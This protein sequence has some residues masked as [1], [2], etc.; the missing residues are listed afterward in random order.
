MLSVLIGTNEEKSRDLLKITSWCS[1][2]HKT[3]RQSS[4]LKYETL[5]M[6]N[7]NGYFKNSN[8]TLVIQVSLDRLMILEHS[9]QTWKGPISLVIYVPVKDMKEGILD[10]QRLVVLQINQNFLI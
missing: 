5:N 7:A 3:S 1:N 9:L 2:S 10:W 4:N 8:I 6:P